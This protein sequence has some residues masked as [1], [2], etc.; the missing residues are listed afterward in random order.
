MIAKIFLKFRGTP[1]N[2]VPQQHY[3]RRAVYIIQGFCNVNHYTIL[4]DFKKTGI[5][6][7]QNL[8]FSGQSNDVNDCRSTQHTFTKL[9]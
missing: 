7:E 4:A 3:R 5:N 6:L 2:L 9:N 1:Q 8:W